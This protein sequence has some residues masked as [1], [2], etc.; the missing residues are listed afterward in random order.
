MSLCECVR[1]TL[2]MQTSPVHCA[3]L[4]ELLHLTERY[5]QFGLSVIAHITRIHAFRMTTRQSISLD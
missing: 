2:Q 3:G 4:A 5:T 1:P